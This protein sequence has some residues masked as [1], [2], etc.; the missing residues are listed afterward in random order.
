MSRRRD[1]RHRPAMPTAQLVLASLR[2]LGVRIALDDFGCDL[3]QGFYLGR[4]LDGD[5]RRVATAGCGG[6]RGRVA[7]RVAV[8]P[9]A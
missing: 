4:P 8:R 3:G 7:L 1:G 6:S 2:A 9:G 5:A